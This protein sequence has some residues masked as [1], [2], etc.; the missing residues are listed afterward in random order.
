MV[1][2]IL[3]F[4]IM[5]SLMA[6]SASAGLKD[7]YLLRVKSND[8]LSAK[9]IDSASYYLSMIIRDTVHAN[10]SD[11]MN[12][13]RCR[14]QLRDTVAFNKYLIYSIENGGADSVIIMS[15][16]RPLDSND[17]AY[18]TAVLPAALA[19]YRP[20]FLK[21][22]DPLIEPE[23]KEIA[24]LDQLCRKTD[25]KGYP[26]DTICENFKTLRTIGHYVD[27][28][29][30]ARVTNLIKRNKYPGFHNFGINS[31]GYDHILMHVSDI[32]EE[33][34]KFI[35]N[36]LKQQLAKGDMMQNQVVA[37]ATRH[38]RHLNCTYFGTQKWGL[39]T[40]C[41]CAQVD[42][43]RKEIGLDSLSEE[44]DRLKQKLPDC[45]LQ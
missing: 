33:Q 31:A 3:L 1:Q 17:K 5:L 10:A 6:G 15:Y 26:K 12:L 20:I 23:M 2:R 44:Y 4:S 37:I 42:K 8:F 29:N 22:V 40:P 16:F 30:F 34:W 13:S 24:F 19:T 28:I 38:Y 41:D 39:T 36:F 45:Y 9:Q 35:Y 11:Y 21:I 7:I 43:I 27:S 25:D 18:L 32:G 14:L